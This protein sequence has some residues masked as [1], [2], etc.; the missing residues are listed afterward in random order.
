MFLYSWV[1]FLR[2]SRI[3]A[4]GLV[5]SLFLPIN[6]AFGKRNAALS[7]FQNNSF[8]VLA[9]SAAL[10]TWAIIDQKLYRRLRYIGLKGKWSF[11]YGQWV[12]A[13]KLSRRLRRQGPGTFFFDPAE[14]SWRFGCYRRLYLAISISGELR[15]WL[16]CGSSS[17]GVPI[18]LVN[19]R[20]K[21]P[22]RYAMSI[23]PGKPG[24]CLFLVWL[25]SSTTGTLV[26]GDCFSPGCVL[27]PGSLVIWF[28]PSTLAAH[29]QEKN[30][31]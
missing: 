11:A 21:Y 16:C 29:W 31:Y 20:R 30:Y 4:W 19:M 27:M 17:L 5:C 12:L 18:L 28:C 1:L 23:V 25:P 26:M 9:L 8:S 7:Q 15:I 14:V 22:C 2:C 24:A 6:N 3:N 10:L 13:I